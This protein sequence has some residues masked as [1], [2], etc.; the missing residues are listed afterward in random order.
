MNRYDSGSLSKFNPLS[1]QELSV[2]PLMQRQ[3]DDQLAV[4]RELLRQGLAK[5]DPLDV[6]TN[7]AIKL[8]N[9]LN[10]QISAQAELIS[11]EGVNSN[12]Q[13]DFL[14]LNRNYQETMSPTGRLGQINAAK[15]VYQKQF[16]DYLEDATKNKGWS[17]ERALANWN[18]FSQEY[19]GFDDDKITNIGQFGAPK[20]IEVME[21]LKDVESLLGEQV[22]G[23]IKASGYSFQPGP[24]GSMVM[25]DRSGR[26]IETSN[27]PNL[28]A[29][30]N[31]IN[32]RLVGKE[33]QDSIRFEGENT[34]NVYNQ[35]TSGINAMLTNKVVDNRNENA[36]YIAPK[37]SDE[38]L[39]TDLDAVNVEGVSITKNLDLLNKMKGGSS[40]R[41]RTAEEIKKEG[42]LGASVLKIDVNDSKEFLKSQDYL[43]LARGIA[44][45][46]KLGSDLKSQKVQD[47]VKKYLTENKDVTVQNRY[48]DANSKPSDL[49]FAS[50][51]NVKDKNAA[52][53]LLMER[54]R[55]GA[56]D[57][58]D[59]EGNIIDNTN[60]G[61][62]K[63]E[64][65]GDMTPKSTVLNK[66]TK[67][68]LF[69]NPKQNIGLRRASLIDEDGKSK[70]VYVSR[71]SDDFNTPQFK[72][73][74]VISGIS[75]I[76]DV[77]P[78]IYHTINSPLFAAY[79]L[80]NVEVKYN[81]NKNTYNLSYKDNDNTD[82]DQEFS[83]SKFQEY[84]LNAYESIN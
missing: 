51:E 76:A 64:Y 13:S 2:V 45:T 73:M 12:S 31:L 10:D 54:V 34:K 25:V 82:V 24:N 53:N 21:V 50:K 80:K 68:P 16:E 32:Q 42:N 15:Q 36:Q 35:L 72:A 78:G 48:V 60:L 39:I 22:V 5:V 83:D 46:Q 11:R 84:I 1:F 77:Q 26:R 17:R 55:T 79:G 75:K 70:T 4:Q 57:M 59:E 14:K 7:E 20:K 58:I 49:L 29:A 74:E 65:N 62:F 23:E 47:A 28:Q 30:Q 52:S 43:K 61:K 6:H 44:R 9:D 63:L 3:K 67:R 40:L 69:N 19:T 27:R 38:N 66:K 37:E 33:W 71:G 8:K 18:N 41:T 56:Y 81:K